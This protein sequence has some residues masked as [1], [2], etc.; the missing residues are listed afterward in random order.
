MYSHLNPKIWLLVL[1][2]FFISHYNIFSQN[3]TCQNSL[4]FC[5]TNIISYAAGVNTGSAQPGPDYACLASQPNPAW[6]YM[7]MQNNGDVTIKIESSPPRDIDFCL[8]GPFDHP[9][10]PCE[11]GLTA[12]KVEDCSYAGGTGPEFADITGGIA[13]EFY[14]LLLTNYSNQ[15]TEVT[16]YQT[17]GNGQLNC[18]IV[19]NCS[20]VAI[21]A[22]PTA[23]NPA[24]NT[25]NV[26]GQII[27]TNPPSTGTL[28]ISDNSGATQ[29]FTPPFVSPK[30][31][32]LN[33]IPCDGTQ[34]TLTASFS[35]NSSCFLSQN[36]SAPEALCPIAVLKG[37][38]DICTGDSLELTIE[39][40]GEPPFNFTYAING[41]AQ[42]PVNNYPGPSPY[43]IYAKEAGIYS[44]VSVSNGLCPGIAS[45]Q[46]TLNLLQL[47]VVNLG[48]DKH[49]CEGETTV[50][51]AGAGFK[52]YQWS[53]G[54]NT[55]TINTS[56]A[57]TY[58]VTVTNF[59]GCQN[60]DTLNIIEHPRPLPLIIKHN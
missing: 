20:V 14:I 7:Q 23:C 34:H 56:T 59:E 43:I 33:N 51:D 30:N 32:S 17:S 8:W 53:T 39:L 5:S 58:I 48:A 10:T 55:Q 35:D 4:V 28:T 24:S 12:D 15:P 25:Y 47:P 31:F 45:G 9:T 19:F 18:N 52:N 3:S 46:A 16:F 26:S 57:G 22:N 11:G 1:V 2:L 27:F 6:F 37:G 42:P 40:S 13:G 36:Y 49:I 41:N 50:L 21:S 38:G 60:S 29:T 54:D 44:M